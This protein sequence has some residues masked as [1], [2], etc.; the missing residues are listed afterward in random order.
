MNKLK[1]K[2]KNE[3]EIPYDFIDEEYMSF[4][5]E[6]PMSVLYYDINDV[7]WTVK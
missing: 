2:T 3:T 6:K 1:L 5:K 7:K 4:K